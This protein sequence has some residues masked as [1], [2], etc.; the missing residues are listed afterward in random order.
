MNSVSVDASQVRQLL[1]DLGLD[2]KETIKA[3][4]GGFLRAATII[5]RQAKTN[6]K[7]V[8]TKSG[9]L[10][11]HQLL[12]YIRK[13]V[14]K[15]GKGV[16]VTALPDNRAST[17]KRLK[18]KGIK[19]KSFV[20]RFFEGGTE[21][22]WTETKRR[23]FGIKGVIKTRNYRGRIQPTNF[24][25]NAVKSKQKEAEQQVNRMIVERINQIVK[26]RK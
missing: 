22:R 7:N 4:R 25:S 13:A 5:Q 8:T 12:A 17:S 1:K 2:N 23:K 11:S 16:Y 26:K 10:K 18:K 15:D 24:F 3:F 19:N 20:L 21:E 6:L 14:Y 9:T